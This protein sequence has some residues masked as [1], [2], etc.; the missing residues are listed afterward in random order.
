MFTEARGLAILLWA[1]VPEAPHR[2][3]TPFFHAA[4]AMDTLV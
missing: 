3:V 2:L 1:R 4:A